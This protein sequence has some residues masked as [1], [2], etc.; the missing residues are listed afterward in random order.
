MQ[1][2]IVEIGKQVIDWRIAVAC[3]N[4]CTILITLTCLRDLNW[5]VGDTI[6]T[7]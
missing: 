7:K 3:D 6:S 2:K 1:V 4:G 5:K